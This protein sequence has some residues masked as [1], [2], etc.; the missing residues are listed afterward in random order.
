[1]NDFYAERVKMMD[2]S[3]L[4]EFMKL[5]SRDDIISF[6]GGIPAT[7]FFPTLEL[8]ELIDQL[9]KDNG[10]QIFQYSSTEGSQQIKE[11]ILEFLEKRNIKAGLENLI[12]T[13]GSQQ[14][15]DLISKIYI[16]PADKI[17]VE[18]PG[19]V[20]GIGAIKSYQANITGI[21]QQQDGINIEQLEEEL[22]VFSRKGERIKFIY[23]VPD[24]SNPTGVRLSLAKRKSV[25][26]L[27]D[28]YNFYIIEDTPYSELNY[29]G[30]RL[31]YIKEFD[32][33]ERIIMLGSFSKFFVPGLRIGWILAEEDTIELL[34]RAKQNADLASNSFGQELIAAAGK[35]GLVEQQI[36]KVIPLYRERLKAM[37]QAL[38][39]YFPDN[40]S[41]FIPQGGFFYW[42]QLPENINSSILFKKAVKNRVA[43][44]TGC[45]FFA[46]PRDGD[47]YIRLSFSN[48]EP[49]E[50]EKGI[51]LLAS[52]IIK[53]S[54]VRIKKPTKT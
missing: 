54:E 51:K 19:Y 11:Y 43:F 33:T 18:K 2:N 20:G 27:A 52:T 7:D 21:E 8:K 25:L 9:I 26:K 44:V 23:L 6:A 13:T 34:G 24:F 16:N 49:A 50:I 5:V 46:D 15:L 47:N 10:G 36:K 22:T 12:I 17:M 3:E 41:W 30:E 32:Q 28:K 40:T 14:A 35:N 42:V 48:T 53:E 38:E 4:S 29:S 45:S 31:P 1:M 39:K 37:G